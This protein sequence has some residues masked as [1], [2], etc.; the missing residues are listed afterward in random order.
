MPVPAPADEK[1]RAGLWHPARPGEA[2]M[3]RPN[4]GGGLAIEVEASA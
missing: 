4:Q 3:G 2:T 1:G